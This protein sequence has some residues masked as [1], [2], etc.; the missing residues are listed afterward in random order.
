MFDPTDLKLDRHPAPV[1]AAAT[2]ACEG[3]IWC[4]LVVHPAALVS[5]SD[6][7]RAAYEQAARTVRRMYPGR[8][9]PPSMN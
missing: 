7:Y 5:P 4:P 8:I 1:A 3:M 2:V 9:V 6:F